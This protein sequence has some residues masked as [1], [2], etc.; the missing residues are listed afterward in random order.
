MKQSKCMAVISAFPC[1][2]SPQRVTRRRIGNTD[3]AS[4]RDVSSISFNEKSH[5][6]G[7][8]VIYGVI[9]CVLLKAA[10][11]RRRIFSDLIIRPY[12]RK[13][14]LLIFKQTLQ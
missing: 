11:R 13:L 10:E 5:C 14:N 3:L 4:K 6:A 2:I 7:E 9:Y 8:C 12:S 1:R